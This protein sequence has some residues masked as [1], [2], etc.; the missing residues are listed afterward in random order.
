MDPNVEYSLDMLNIHIRTGVKILERMASDFP[1]LKRF[2]HY[3]QFAEVLTPTGLLGAIREKIQDK[4]LRGF[5]S[6]KIYNNMSYDLL[7]CYMAEAAE[8][9]SNAQIKVQQMI[10]K[11]NPLFYD[12]ARAI[13]D[14]LI[15][16]HKEWKAIAPN[17]YLIGIPLED[18]EK[19]GLGAQLEYE[20]HRQIVRM[21]LPKGEYE[22][23]KSH[24]RYVDNAGKGCMVV[25]AITFASSL[26][27]ACTLL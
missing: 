1:N 6:T 24:V 27:A 25:I 12:N 5:L 15:K 21:E 26:L 3:S 19:V 9:L 10:D 11:S 16:Y 7:G 13:T 17:V 22:Q 4:R 2:S 23:I 20:T 14:A 8:D 18:G